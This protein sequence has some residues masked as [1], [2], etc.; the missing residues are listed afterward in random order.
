MSAAGPALVTGASAG[1]GRELAKV[2]AAHGHDLAIVA[3]NEERLEEFAAELRASFG[4]RVEVVPQDLTRPG[5]PSRV[6]E[7]I[8]RRGLGIEILVNNAGV[9]RSGRF[10]DLSVEDLEDLLQLNVSAATTLTR[11]CVAA[12]LER[13]RGRVL[14]VCSLAGFQPLP[15]LAVY[16]ASKAYLLSFTEALAEELRGS[17]V[18]VTALCPGL[19]RTQMTE[20]TWLAPFGRER[21]PDFIVSSAPDVA[22]AGY[23]ACLRGVVTE[24][25]GA[26]NAWYAAWSRLQPRW[27]ARSLWG[28]AS[29]QGP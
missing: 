18:T 11:L 28:I 15:L 10:Q 24:V 23:W 19:T 2:F 5:A 3:R 12:F 9:A 16:A 22:R 6:V 1:I 7:E 25:P 13:G 29:R 4:R 20:E 14:N 17:G 26:A 8:E 27:L 21:L